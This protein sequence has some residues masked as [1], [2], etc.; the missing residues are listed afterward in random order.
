VGRLPFIL[1]VCYTSVDFHIWARVDNRGLGLVDYLPGSLLALVAFFLTK[2]ILGRKKQINE[3]EEIRNRM[4]Q[5]EDF[6]VH[7]H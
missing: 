4:T 3:F 7:R 1:G 2:F 6:E 5:A